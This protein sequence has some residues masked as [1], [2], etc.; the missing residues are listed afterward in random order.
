MIDI[1]RKDLAMMM[2][3][4]Y[5]LV[6]MQR[7]K[8]AR[9]VFEGI[10]VLAPESEIPIVAI[11]SVAFCEGKFKESVK[12]YKKALKLNAESHFAEAYMGEALF[13]LGEIEAAKTNLSNVIQCDT[14]GKAGAFAKS[15]LDA[16]E[17]GFTPNMLSGVD[18]FK[19]YEKD[20][21]QTDAT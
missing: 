18:D 19:A 7:F 1:D 20:Q 11:G 3:C 6:G 10:G 8:E 2:E 5:I 16:I 21:E 13:F 4:G 9:Q 12:Y 14:E 17:Q 15:L